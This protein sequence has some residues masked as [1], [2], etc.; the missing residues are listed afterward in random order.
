MS[1][2]KRNLQDVW[3][4]AVCE[5]QSFTLLKYFHRPFFCAHQAVSLWQFF[6]SILLHSSQR[7]NILFI[8]LT[9]F[10]GCVLANFGY[11]GVNCTAYIRD[12]V[13]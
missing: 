1:R 12:A 7:E 9:K 5:L 11:T 3:K 4:T 8:T 6:Y 10:R 2:N 13:K